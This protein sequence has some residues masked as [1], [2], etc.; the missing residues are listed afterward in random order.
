MTSAL[1]AVGSRLWWLLRESGLQVTQ[2]IVCEG[3]DPDDTAFLMQLIEQFHEMLTLAFGA[4]T[5]E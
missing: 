4:I 5:T 3:I 1:R 2:S